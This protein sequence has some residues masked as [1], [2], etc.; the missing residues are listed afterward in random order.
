M[1]LK[2]L[3]C[4]GSGWGRLPVM[5]A[6]A[7]GRSAKAADE[8]GGALTEQPLTLLPKP[9]TIG[10][11]AEPYVSGVARVT[12]DRGCILVIASDG[13]W[14]VS[15]AEHV[16]ACVLQADRQEMTGLGAAQ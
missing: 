10:L 6:Q 14:D 11:S 13:L 16:A 12:Q 4:G 7:T 2:F 15:D 8:G 9:V 5:A 1:F 3:A